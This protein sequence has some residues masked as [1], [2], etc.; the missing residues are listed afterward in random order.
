MKKKIILMLFALFIA[1]TMG[2]CADSSSNV[3]ISINDG[4]NVSIT[5]MQSKVHRGNHLQIEGDPIL[6]TD[7][8]EQVH[9]V[10]QSG[11]RL[12][13]LILHVGIVFVAMAKAPTSRLRGSAVEAD[14]PNS[15]HCV[16]RKPQK[17]RD[18]IGVKLSHDGKVGIAAVPSIHAKPL[19]YFSI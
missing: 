14:L 11:N 19:P 3:G 10:P 2:A 5:V 13:H 6:P 4:N 15:A 18:G 7:P 16:G 9:L 17:H 12:S 1:C 8:I